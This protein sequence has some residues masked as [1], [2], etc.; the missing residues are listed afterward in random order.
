MNGHG[1][2]FEK[3]RRQTFGS[4]SPL[5]R[6]TINRRKRKAYFRGVESYNT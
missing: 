2:T 5:A 4:Y 3:N 6:K 1:L